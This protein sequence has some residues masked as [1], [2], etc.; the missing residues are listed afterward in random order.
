MN[1]RHVVAALL[2]APLLTLFAAA[3]TAATTVP[4]FTTEQ[5]AQQADLVAR[6]VIVAKRVERV[7]K[8]GRLATFYEVRV[9]D[10]WKA[11]AAGAPATALIALPGGVLHGIGQ[12]VPGTPV[13]H[14]GDDLVVFLSAPVGPKGARATIGLWQGVL[15]VGATAGAPLVPFTHDAPPAPGA[16]TVDLDALRSRVLG[17]PR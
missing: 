6:V 7:G 12:L 4:T 8:A 10:A 15:R 5:L 11:P 9:T 2:T 13:L 3:P 14:V 1:R 16:P 17:T